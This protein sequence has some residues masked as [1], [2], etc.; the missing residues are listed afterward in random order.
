MKFT[1]RPYQRTF[2]RKAMDAMEKGV[3]GQFFSKFLGIAATGAGK[4]IIGS[5]LLEYT[6]RWGITP[7][8]GLFLADTDELVFQTVDKIRACTNIIP[9]VEKAASRAS[10]EADIV[11]GS[12]QSMSRRLEDYLKD[13]FRLVIA[14]E[15]HLSL[16]P[17]WQRTLEYFRE[18]GA[19]ILGVT[20]TPG[21]G[22]NQQLMDYYEH[23]V[24]EIPLKLLIEQRM[25]SPI[26]VQTEPLEIPIHST[27]TDG[28]NE[29]LAE[30]L[31]PYYEAIIDSMER[32]AKD[33]R[34][35]LVFHTSIAASI[36]FTSLLRQRGHKA[37]HVD[38]TTS[39]RGEIIADFG[40]PEG[41]RILNNVQLLTKGYDGP[42]VDCIIILRP[43]KSRTAYTQMVGRGTRLYCPHGCT[44]WCEHADRKANMLLLDYLWEF[45]DKGVM[46]PANLFSESPEQ[47]ADVY[48]GLRAGTGKQLDLMEM[49]SDKFAKREQAL[50][51]KLKRVT[52]KQGRRMDA[53]DFAAMLHQPDLIDYKPLAKWEAAPATD[54]Q[55]AMLDKL[56]LSTGC[57]GEASQMIKV[58]AERMEDH[59]ASPK[60]VK[61]LLEEGYGEAH[62]Y[63]FSK[64]SRLIDEIRAERT[65][66]KTYANSR[67]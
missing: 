55:L 7:G 26:V 42:M 37:M 9:D 24:D 67:Y 59:R 18:G 3:D 21:R 13:H 57:R 33:R 25:L 65:K 20:A 47:V 40:K 61:F 41:I 45:A 5:A 11:V 52:G 54:R 51:E 38:G 63:S 58:L 64:A 14:D 2:C 56:G 48:A 44:E 50:L 53:M 16:A 35:I 8:K 30:E 17:Q 62:R 1:L 29:N 66:D 46:S 34:K 22:D 19:F 4:T 36:H 12:I 31:T 6:N 27:V 10:K 32:E 15:A 49:D 23:L 60:Q 28:D 39:G 43:V